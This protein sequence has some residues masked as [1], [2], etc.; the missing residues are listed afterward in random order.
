VY[1]LLALVCLRTTYFQGDDGFYPQKEGMAMGS[2]LSP[3]VSNIYVEHFAQLAVDSVQDKPSLWLRYVDYTFVIWP[4][5]AEGIQN[6]LTHL[7]SLRPAIQFTME[8]ES[9]EMIPFLDILVKKTGTALTMKI[10][11]KP[12]HTG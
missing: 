9:E 2:F 12:T 5:G 8:I 3:I 4:H 1:P 6:F 7:N 11:R 10:Y